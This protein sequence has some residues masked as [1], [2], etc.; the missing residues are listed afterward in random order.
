MEP[1]MAKSAAAELVVA[2][3]IRRGLSWVD[4]AD[5]LGAPLVWAT[6]ALLGQHPMTPEQAHIV[7]E[8]L[9]LD[10]KVAESLRSQPARGVDPAIMR[11]PTVYRL[12]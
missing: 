9:E 2:A 5:A 12:V 8:L 4:I 10:D 6:A 3:G 7:C 11:D 1:I